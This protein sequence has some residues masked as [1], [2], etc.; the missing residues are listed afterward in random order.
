MSKTA[1]TDLDELT[2]EFH[3]RLQV[4]QMVNQTLALLV[5]QD[6]LYQDFLTQLDAPRTRR[7]VVKHLCHRLCDALRW[8]KAGPAADEPVSEI[9]LAQDAYYVVGEDGGVTQLTE[10]STQPETQP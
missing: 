6:R 4:S 3:R 9:A 10:E 7:G 8:R 5:S 1:R 2:A